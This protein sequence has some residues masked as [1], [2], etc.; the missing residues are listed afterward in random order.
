MEDDNLILGQPLSI[1]TPN[2]NG[3][4]DITPNPNL[5][6]K[7]IRKYSTKAR[8]ITQHDKEGNLIAEYPSQGAAAEAL[9]GT[10]EGICQ[11]LKQRQAGKNRHYKGFIWKYKI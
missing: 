1:A 2:E 6:P 4:F 11:A 8:P 7:A 9:D 3:G 5:K 10:A